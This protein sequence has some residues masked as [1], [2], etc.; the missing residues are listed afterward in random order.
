MSLMPAGSRNPFTKMDRQSVVGALKATGSGDADVFHSKRN[1][2][3]SAPTQLT[4]L[5]VICMV[6]GAIFTVTV[7][8]A[9]VGIPCVIFG[10][11][12]WNP[13][14]GRWNSQGNGAS[15][16]AGSNGDMATPANALIGGMTAGMCDAM[17]G[18]GT[19]SSAPRHW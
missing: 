13:L 5:G 16:K 11:W 1:E 2:L 6:I 4:L 7:I 14:L 9:I 17:L 18:R 15:N 8:L 10:W 19:S 12:C 3:L